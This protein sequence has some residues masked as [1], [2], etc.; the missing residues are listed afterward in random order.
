M[1][2]MGMLFWIVFGMGEIESCVMSF[3][4]RAIDTGLENLFEVWND[5]FIKKVNVC[6]VIARS[7]TLILSLHFQI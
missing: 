5:F 2:L 4:R 3:H 1:K 7:I 6:F